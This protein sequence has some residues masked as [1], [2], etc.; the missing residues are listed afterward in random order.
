M[1][2]NRAENPL[3][4]SVNIQMQRINEFRAMM[5]KYLTAAVPVLTNSAGDSTKQ[6]Q[7]PQQ[8]AVTS[9]ES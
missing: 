3:I 6:Q 5:Q 1:D 2:A 7:Q 8:Q 9:M 4:H